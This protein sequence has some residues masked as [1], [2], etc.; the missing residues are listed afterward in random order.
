MKK[1]NK[2]ESNLIVDSLNY[3]VANLESEIKQMEENGKPS[4]FSPGF[5]TMF[6]NELIDK[7]QKDMTKKQRV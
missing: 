2:M 6:A 7:V 5:Y 3:Y 1:F 4:I